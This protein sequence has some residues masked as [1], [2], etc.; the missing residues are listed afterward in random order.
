[1][2][3]IVAQLMV[4]FFIIIGAIV[5]TK[6]CLF[7]TNPQDMSSVFLSLMLVNIVW[8]TV[9]IELENVVKIFKK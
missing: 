4:W 2:I 3:K 6:I 7:N 5:V 8:I 9:G 1:M